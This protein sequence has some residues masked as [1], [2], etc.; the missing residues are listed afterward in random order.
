MQFRF[1][2][3]LQKRLEMRPEIGPSYEELRV[4]LGLSSKSGVARLVESC[5]ERGRIKRLPNRDR[6]L[7]VLKPVN[8]GSRPGAELISSFTDRELLHE[9]QRR[10]LLVMKI[11]AEKE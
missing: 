8:E 7:V 5:I 6:S 9:I 11:P 3:A 10:G 2:L 4:D 1:M